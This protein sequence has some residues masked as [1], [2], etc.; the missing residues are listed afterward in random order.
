MS[1]LLHLL[2][3]HVRDIGF[4]VQRLLPAAAVPAVGPFVFFD[5]MGPA[6]FPAGTTEGDVR[7]H[8]HIGLSTFT[9]LFSGALLHRDSL[10]VTQRIEPGAVNWMTAG[11]GVVHS[12]RIPADIR[13]SGQE[14][15]G[16]QMWLAAPADREDDAPGFHHYP[17]EAL[18]LIETSGARLR[19]LAGAFQG[20]VSPV[21]TEMPTLCASAELEARASMTLPVEVEVEE[22]AV[23][24]AT[25]ELALAGQ[26]L[27]AGQMAILDP[28]TENVARATQPTRFMLLGGQ[29]LDGKRLIWWNFVATSRERIEAAK[30]A[31]AQEQFPLVPGE[32]ERIPLPAGSLAA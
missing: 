9:Y 14:V 17:A 11:R 23:Y 32:T 21:R 16:L 2:R 6:T 10:G 7:P 27:V 24:V 26:T 28:R 15:E 13:D 5:H 31:W 12:E 18:P 3:P 25:G 4:P 29:R 20:A 19:V 1:A 8:P 22:L 30:V